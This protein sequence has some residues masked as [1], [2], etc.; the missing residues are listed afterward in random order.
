MSVGVK[1]P[2]GLRLQQRHK[3]S[4]IPLGD[5]TPGLVLERLSVRFRDRG[6]QIS[7]SGGTSP[8]AVVNA[9][10]SLAYSL[11]SADNPARRCGIH[12]NGRGVPV[13]VAPRL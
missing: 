8:R 7:P 10:T 2:L 4:C 5:V 1:S 9:L 3:A 12:A 11:A 6:A 13:G